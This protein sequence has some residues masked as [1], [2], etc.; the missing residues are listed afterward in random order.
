MGWTILSFGQNFQKRGCVCNILSFGQNF[1]KEL[2]GLN[3]IVFWS[4]LS[5][6]TIWVEPYCLLVKIFLTDNMGWTILSIGQNFQKAQYGKK[7]FVFWTK[8]LKKTIWV[9]P[10]CLLNNLFLR[11]I[12]VERHCLF[13]KT[14]E[15]DNMGWTILC[16]GQ[17]F[18]KRQ[19]VLNHILFWSKFS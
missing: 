18:Q 15:K 3:H 9:E 19:L 14:F 12:W 17:N 13:V 4:K 5:K 11:A 1:L 7:Y 2:Y 6:K 16:F 8:L 10:Y